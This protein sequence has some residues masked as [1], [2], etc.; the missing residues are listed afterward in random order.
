MVYLVYAVFLYTVF[1][2]CC[3]WCMLYLV[4]AANSVNTWLWQAEIDMDD[5]TS[6]SAIMVELWTRK[7]HVGSRWEWYGGI[8]HIWE[9]RG[10][11]AKCILMTGNIWEPLGVCE[12]WQNGI[13]G[14]LNLGVYWTDAVAF[15]CTSDSLGVLASCLEA[16]TT[17]LGAHG[18]TGDKLE[19]VND[20]S[21]STDQN[22]ASTLNQC[23]IVWEIHRLWE[24]FWCAWKS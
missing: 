19:H 15:R 9:I 8:K 2:V 7:K 17:I 3:I 18:S 11:S 23:R 24:H 13:Q 16:P 4:Y 5:L 21:P 22:P 6:C 20:K 1:G 12:S 14:W 10:I